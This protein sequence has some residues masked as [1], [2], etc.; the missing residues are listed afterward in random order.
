MRP[1]TNAQ[2]SRPLPA[3]LPTF[4]SHGFRARGLRQAWLAGVIL[5]LALL[6][7]WAARPRVAPHPIRDLQKNGVHGV[8][9]LHA[10]NGELLLYNFRAIEEGKLY[11]ASEFPRNHRASLGGNL[12]QAA[13][14][15]REAF[16]LLRGKRIRVIIT[17]AGPNEYYAEQGYLESYAKQTGYKIRLISL[18]TSPQLAYVHQSRDGRRFGLRTAVEF[19]DFMKNQAPKD[20]AVLLHGYGGKDAVGVVAAAYELWRNAGHADRETLWRQ[21]SERYLVSDTLIKRDKDAA[22]FAGKPYVCSNAARAY[23]CPE[24]LESLRPDLERI[25]Q[26]N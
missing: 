5:A 17:L 19:I 6:F 2:T 8:Y 14:L 9:N 1:T 7:L 15:S 25:A 10:K 3:S 13:F 23:V 12:Q 22:K 20:G 18:T 16:D 11:R 21:V 26:V 24:L 4:G